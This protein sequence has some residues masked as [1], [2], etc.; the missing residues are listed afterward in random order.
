MLIDRDK[1]IN[2]SRFYQSVVIQI[3]LSFNTFWLIGKNFSSVLTNVFQNG[4]IIK[5]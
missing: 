3:F 2:I 5:C 4:V 1:E